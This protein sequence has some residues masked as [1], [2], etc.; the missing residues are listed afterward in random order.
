MVYVYILESEAR[1]GKTYVWFTHDLKGRFATH[2]RGESPYTAKFRP[3]KLI[4]YVAVRT[5]DQA[6]ALERY[7]KT[8]SGMAFW[9]KRLR[10]KAAAVPTGPPKP[11]A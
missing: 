7:F 11:K 6:I 4:A 5:E 10:G 9:K 3:W 8:G 2:N 1:A